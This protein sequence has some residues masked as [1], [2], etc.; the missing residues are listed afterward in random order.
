MLGLH[1]PALGLYFLK[2]GLHVQPQKYI[3]LHPCRGTQVCSL[4]R[5]KNIFSANIY[6]ELDFQL[7]M[8]ILETLADLE[9]GLGAN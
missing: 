4:S 5:H 2:L 1:S 9:R 6:V 8:V 7:V 3:N